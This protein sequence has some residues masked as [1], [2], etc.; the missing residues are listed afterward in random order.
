MSGLMLLLFT[1]WLLKSL[2]YTYTFICLKC[3]RIYI[4]MYQLNVA[5]EIYCGSLPQIPFGQ[6]NDS[7]CNST[8]LQYPAVC[9]LTCQENYQL[10]GN[11]TVVCGED[12]IFTPTVLPTCDG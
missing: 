9:K 1:L 5:E 2:D 4:Y 12:G 7:L 10:V 6:W 3:I 11:D 8:E